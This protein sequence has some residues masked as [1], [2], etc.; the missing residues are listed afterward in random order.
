MSA[1]KRVF[2]GIAGLWLLVEG[3]GDL[4]T[5]STEATLFD[6]WKGGLRLAFV[7]PADWGFVLLFVAIHLG[8]GVFCLWEFLRPKSTSDAA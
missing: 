8:G 1:L 4:Y 7:W 3:L 6:T 5:L 2:V